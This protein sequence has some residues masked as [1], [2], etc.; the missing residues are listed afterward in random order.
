MNLFHLRETRTAKLAEIKA[1]GDNPDNAK[2][3]AIESE[4]RALDS[5]IKNAATIAEFER[6][7]ATPQGDAM[8]RELRSYS[9]SK[10]IREG[11]S[12]NLTGLEREVHEELSRGREVRGLMIPT[13]AIFGDENR[14]MLTTGTAGNTVATDMGGLIDRI[15]PT[16]AVQGLGAT[17]ISGL[18]GNLDL[19]RLTSGPTAHWVNEDEATTASDATFDKVSLK[20]K[21]VS[22]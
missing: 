2:F 4:I 8:A 20:P 19:P 7:E 16:L 14:A 3:T 13:A 22:G 6:H 17:I 5:Q 9:V 18:T 10:A 1:L 15:R 21:T 11:N 12:D